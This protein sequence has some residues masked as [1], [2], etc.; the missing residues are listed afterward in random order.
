MFESL[1]YFHRQ[2]KRHFLYTIGID[3]RFVLLRTNQNAW[4]SIPPV[5][6]LLYRVSLMKN[7]TKFYFC[8]TVCMVLLSKMAA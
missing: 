7:D 2:S 3:I 6:Q 4:F 5:N 8:D 1:E